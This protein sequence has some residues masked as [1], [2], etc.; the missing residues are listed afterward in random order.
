MEQ[1]L[2]HLMALQKLDKEL[3]GIVSLRGDLPQQ[4]KALNRELEAAKEAVAE[5]DARI[6]D[7]RLERSS[8]E[9]E[10]QGLSERQ[11]KYKAQLF[12]V[13]NNREYDAVT[14]ELEAVRQAS[15]LVETRILELMDLEGEAQ[16]D[17][18]AKVQ[19]LEAIQAAF[20]GKKQD[21]EEA[22]AR[23]EK[24]ETALRDRREAL[25]QT[26]QPRILNSYER[27]LKAK[28]GSAVVPVIRNACGGCFETLPPQRVLEVRQMIRLN[29][30]ETCGRMLVWDPELSEAEQ[31]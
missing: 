11:E 12:A 2:K 21:L 15:S 4:V 9:L 16:K 7:Y 29:L 19:A 26:L 23:T 3:N 25:A 27:I 24:E 18:E 14:L 6:E 28:N 30:C 1:A 22:I 20:E 17:R 10:T 31:E 5:V 13:K 8:K